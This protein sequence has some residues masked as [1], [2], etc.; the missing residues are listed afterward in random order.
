MN[1]PLDFI[2]VPPL[3]DE[4]DG[5]LH[6]LRKGAQTS[7]GERTSDNWTYVALK[8]RIMGYAISVVGEC[9]T[10][11]LSPI[12]L[13]ELV[14]SFPNI[15][16]ASV[17]SPDWLPLHWAVAV[18]GSIT[19]ADIELLLQHSPMSCREPSR[20]SRMALPIHLLACISHPRL[21][22]AEEL[23]AAFPFSV[24]QADAEGY[25]P[26]HYAALHT[27]SV[28]FLQFLLQADS[29]AILRTTRDHL[30]CLHLAVD[31][32]CNAVLCA[33]LD[34]WPS[35]FFSSAGAESPFFYAIRRGKA[36]A[37]ASMLSTHPTLVREH[38]AA[39]VL[40]LHLAAR[41]SS[42]DVVSILLDADPQ[43]L[44]GWNTSITSGGTFPVC[45]SDSTYL[46]R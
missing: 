34:V 19:P 11:C 28:A 39:Q 23:V 42:L 35:D 22:I 18:S 27:S 30:S 38:T 41:V 43:V 10:S 8:V 9:M 25:L 13:R 24:M 31:N 29:R 12:P 20:S 36:E 37:V 21:D 7:S 26:V 2:A 14:E 32:P 45:S 40:P 46:L 6:T 3:K 15:E 33:L 4:T 16:H 1:S 5:L 17:E 44:V